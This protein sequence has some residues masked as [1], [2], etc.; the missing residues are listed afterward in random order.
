MYYE[1]SD[2][3]Q[4]Q[5]YEMKQQIKDKKSGT[6]PDVDYNIP[7][8]RI[9]WKHLKYVAVVKNTRVISVFFAVLEKLKR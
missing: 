5:K 2:I 1:S 3:L 4:R 9:I 8:R 7:Y 6:K